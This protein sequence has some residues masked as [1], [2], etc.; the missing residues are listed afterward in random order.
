MA[1]VLGLGAT[2]FGGGDR[3]SIYLE[4]E[5]VGLNEIERLLF[6]YG[7]RAQ[8]ELERSVV[9]KAELIM[10][11]AKLETPVDRG[12]LRASGHVPKPTIEDGDFVVRPAFGGVATPYAFRQ[13]EELGYRHNVGNAKYLENP[14]R[15][16]FAGIDAWV[17]NDMRARLPK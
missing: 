9:K 6:Q 13:H 16:H 12:P 7:A 17:A 2:L 14:A 8:R 15:R 11:E 5:M 10:G 4:L 3:R 1:G